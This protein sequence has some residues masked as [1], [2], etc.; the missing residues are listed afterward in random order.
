ML[1]KTVHF[2]M[3]MGNY[4]MLMNKPKEGSFFLTESQINFK[5]KYKIMFPNWI[6]IVTNSNI[7]DVL[8]IFISTFILKKMKMFLFPSWKRLHEL[9]EDKNLIL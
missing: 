4:Q 3:K 5:P 9:N 1:V 6:C 7:F 8:Y 2:N